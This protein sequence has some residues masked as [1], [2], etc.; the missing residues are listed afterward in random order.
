MKLGYACINESL[1]SDGRFKTTTVTSAGKLT[2]EERLLKLKRISLEN[3]HTVYRILQWNLKHDIFV[4]RV[5]SALIPLDG[6]EL[7]VFDW[8][9]DE[10]VLFICAKIKLF[11]FLNNM[12]IS[13]HPDQFCVL[14]SH[15]PE[16]VKNSIQILNYHNVLCNLLGSKSIV[17]HVGSTNGGKEESMQR[18][19]NTFKTLDKDIQDK[20]IL[21]NDDKSYNIQDVLNICNTIKI[22]CCLDIHHNNC[23]RAENDLSQYINEIALTWKARNETPKCH[24]STGNSSKTDRKHA[25][26]IDYNDYLHAVSLLKDYDFDIMFECKM[27]EKSIL[28]IRR[29]GNA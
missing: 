12:R 9:N 14:S 4:Y 28:N 16:V 10:D 11:V 29:E 3:L 5:S 2:E 7:N 1:G 8:A 22:P 26:Y 13:M 18:F 24:L 27:K 25:D 19:I 6:H 23:N 20:I 17:L 21:E 15:N